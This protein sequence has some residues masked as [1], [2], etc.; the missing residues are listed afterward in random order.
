MYHITY[1]KNTDTINYLQK[2]MQSHS[3]DFLKMQG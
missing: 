1:Y 2:E 3:A